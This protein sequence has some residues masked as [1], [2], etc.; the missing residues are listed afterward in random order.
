[1]PGRVLNQGMANSQG[2][3]VVFLNADCTPTH[4]DWLARLIEPFNDEQV[5]ASFGRQDPRPDCPTLLAK[6]TFMT[7]GDGEQQARWRHCFSM[8]AS[9][10]RRRVWQEMPFDEGLGY[11]EDID[12]TW[13]AR[14]KGFQIRYAPQ[15]RALH[16]NNYGLSGHWRRQYGEGKAEA[17]IFDWPGWQASLLRYSLL[18]LGRQVLSDLRWCAKRGQWQGAIYSPLWRLVQMA[19]RRRGFC[20]GRRKGRPGE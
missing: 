8:A 7:Y 1:M 11:S 13:R 20:A 15:A 17:V 14:Q 18:P 19:A 10:I 6:D 5:A 9:A 12:W 16:S 3:V 2:E 4:P